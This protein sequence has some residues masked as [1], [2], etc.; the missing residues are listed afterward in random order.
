MLEL[1]EDENTNTYAK[2]TESGLGA[3]TSLG[4]EVYGRWSEQCVK[5]V[6]ALACERA[7]GVRPRLRRG[8]VLSLQHRWWGLLGTALQK[9]VAHQVLHASAGADLVQT[10]LE[11]MPPLGEVAS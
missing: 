8:I 5:L 7:R 1:A 9:A 3:L 6:P 4:C 2:V 10:Q 11:P